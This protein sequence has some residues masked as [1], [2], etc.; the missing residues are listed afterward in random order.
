MS[1]AVYDFPTTDKQDCLRGWQA[2]FNTN[3]HFLHAKPPPRCLE[4]TDGPSEGESTWP[5]ILNPGRSR[6][7]WEQVW[8]DMRVGRERRS[9]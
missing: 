1:D 2:D 4:R 9:R 8:T 6:A 7:D 3:D 5:Y